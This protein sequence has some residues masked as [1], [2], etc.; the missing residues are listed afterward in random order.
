MNYTSLFP[1][2]FN[3]LLIFSVLSIFVLVIS[4]AKKKY[5][6]KLTLLAGILLLFV[7]YYAKS[8]IV[9]YGTGIAEFILLGF[10]IFGM[11]SASK[12]NKKLQE[13]T[14]KKNEEIVENK[15]DDN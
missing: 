5:F 9:F 7:L 6:Y 13:E 12:K 4:F 8:K 14:N 11:V 3:Y 10:T 2:P 1:L 15:T